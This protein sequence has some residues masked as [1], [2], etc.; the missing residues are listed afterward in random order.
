M[1]LQYGIDGI[2]MNN[3]VFRD[4]KWNNEFRQ[5]EPLAGDFDG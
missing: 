4:F 1:M 5:I 2:V 3:L